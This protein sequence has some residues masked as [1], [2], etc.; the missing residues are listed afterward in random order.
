[1]AEDR[2][3]RDDAQSNKEAATIDNP[4][5]HHDE[6][7]IEPAADAARPIGASDP[8]DVADSASVDLTRCGWCGGTQFIP[9]PRESGRIYCECGSVYNPLTARWT[10]GQQ[11]KR[12]SP[13]A[14][15]PVTAAYRTA[16]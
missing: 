13:P 4:G 7:A 14:P 2:T 11:D 10:P 16:R 6:E 1:M 12:Q 8:A 3:T 9:T 15:L 5:P